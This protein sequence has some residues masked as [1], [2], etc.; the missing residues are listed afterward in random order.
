M[1]DELCGPGESGFK[2]FQLSGLA[3]E[4]IDAEYVEADLG[5]VGKCKLAE[6]AA[7][8]AAQSSA[9]VLIDGCLGWGASRAVRALTSMKQSRLPCQA[10][11]STSPGMSPEVQRR[12]TTV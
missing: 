6:V 9:F 5:R 12:A 7:G 4:N 1:A 10:T 8:E 2:V 3:G 11:R